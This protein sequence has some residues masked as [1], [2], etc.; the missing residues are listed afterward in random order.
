[1]AL[2]REFEIGGRH[3][4]AVILH[5]HPADAALLQGHG[6]AGGA[7]VEGVLHQLLHHRGRPLHHLAGGDAVG[8][9]LGEDADGGMDSRV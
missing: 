4:G 7:G 1:M 6:D 5:H 3:A 8:G 9:G 2:H